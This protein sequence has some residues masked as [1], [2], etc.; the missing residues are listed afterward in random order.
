MQVSPPAYRALIE[1]LDELPGVGPEAAA[2][3]SEWLVYQD[4][5]GRLSQIFSELSAS[6]C[7]DGCNLIAPSLPCSVCTDAVAGP[8]IVVTTVADAQSL[9]SAAVRL[10]L[11]CLHGLLSPA[12]G[13]GPAQLKLDR[14]FLR[15]QSFTEV[16]VAT[17]GSVE[18]QVT[19]DY[20]IRRSGLSG[21]MLTVSEIID[22]YR[23]T[24]E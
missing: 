19:A 1:A 8:L 4:K 23:E 9:R 16:V 7:C 17:S 3:F 13:V 14:L 6:V 2:R 20:I 12:Q 5:A 21:R 18:G 15:L 10:P 11:F 24:D 22:I